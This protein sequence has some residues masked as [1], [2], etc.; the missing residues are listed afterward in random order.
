[1]FNAFNNNNRFVGDLLSVFSTDVQATAKRVVEDYT[2][3]LAAIEEKDPVSKLSLYANDPIAS[4]QTFVDNL[5]RVEKLAATTTASVQKEM[6]PLAG[7][8]DITKIRQRGIDTLK[9]AMAEIK[10]LEENS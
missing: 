4:L 5:D 2:T 6:A 3:L 1:M 8:K 9:H 10:K 7:G